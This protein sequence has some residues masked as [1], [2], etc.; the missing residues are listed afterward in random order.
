MEFARC[1][2]NDVI[3]TARQFAGLP[4]DALSD[5]RRSL[6]CTECGG[7][8]FFRAH[9]RNDREACFGAWPHA[10]HCQLRA[11]QTAAHASGHAQVDN[12]P[13]QRLVVDFE[14]GAPVLWDHSTQTPE[15]ESVRA[16]IEAVAGSGF[17]PTQVQHMRLRPL[18]R[19][20]TSPTPCQTSPQWVDVA[21]FGTFA[22]AD[23][24]VPFEAATPMHNYQWHGFFGQ[25]VSAHFVGLNTLW[26]NSGGYAS[27][28]I[29][30]PVQFVDELFSRFGISDK[31]QLAGARVLVF[32]SLQISQSGKWYVVLQDLNHITIDLGRD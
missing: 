22:V 1:T 21:G 10:D 5:R 18:L 11:A 27:P 28:G 16:Q 9:T 8:A 13:A 15:A 24:F 30:V 2:Q 14:Y 20:L 17:N 25:L 3:Y 6:V 26:L 32:G 12:R 23:F 31:R 7:R 4:T 19:L 29:C